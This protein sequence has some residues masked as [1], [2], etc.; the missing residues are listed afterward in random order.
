MV[1][2]HDLPPLESGDAKVCKQVS[3]RAHGA[4]KSADDDP[5]LA[6]EKAEAAGLD[7][8]STGV[9]DAL[10]MPQRTHHTDAAG[11]SKPSAQCNL[12]DPES[13]MLKG[14]ECWIQGYN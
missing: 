14:S 13:H 2:D 7:L 10:A 8:F 12:N 5:E 11:S 1:H 9:T 6:I 3:R 4:R